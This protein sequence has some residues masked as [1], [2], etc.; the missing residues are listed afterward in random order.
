MLYEGI[1]LEH[2]AGKVSM[3]HS[4]ILD[5]IHG[6]SSTQNMDWMDKLGTIP[7]SIFKDA[8]PQSFEHASKIFSL[9]NMDYQVCNGGIG[10]YFGNSYHTAREPFHENDVARYDIDVQKAYFSDI[11]SFAKAL[12]PERVSENASLEAACAAF[13]ELAYEESVEFTETIECD[14]DEYIYDENLDEYVLNPDYFEPYDETT[15]EDVIHGD[16]G[17]DDIFYAA[18]DYLEELLELQSQLCCKKLVLEV[19]KNMGRESELMGELKGIL[20]SNAFAKRSLS[21]QIQ[22]ASSRQGVSHDDFLEPER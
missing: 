14:E 12:Y 2:A 16:E 15:Y 5:M 9:A 11:V 3:S 22:S 18:N 8:H 13:Q 19:D 20:P 21:E 7:W 1:D 6:E 10:Q 17:F 4:V